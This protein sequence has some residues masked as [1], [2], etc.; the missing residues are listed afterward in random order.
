MQR[1]KL[2]NMAQMHPPSKVVLHW[3]YGTLLPSQVPQPTCY[4]KWVGVP[5]PLKQ[6]N[7]T[8]EASWA[9]KMARNPCQRAIIGKVGVYRATFQK[10][11]LPY[12]HRLRRYSCLMGAANFQ[13]RQRQK[14]YKDLL[15][16][17][18]VFVNSNVCICCP[19]SCSYQ[20]DTVF[21]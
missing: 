9:F 2:W 5:I 3:E 8:S 16:F 4:W 14:M 1:E 20:C 6:D 18:V 12:M 15:H 7:F 11:E 13:V 10:T 19:V 21:T 17:P